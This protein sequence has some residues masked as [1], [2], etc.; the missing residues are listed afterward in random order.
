MEYRRNR[1]DGRY[2]TSPTWSQ[3]AAE[4][5]TKDEA[6]ADAKAAAKA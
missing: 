4:A 1:E 2:C 6:M 5:T 3:G